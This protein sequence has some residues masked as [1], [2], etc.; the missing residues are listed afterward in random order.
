MG[1]EVVVAAEKKNESEKETVAKRAD[2]LRK[3]RLRIAKQG[4]S[5][6]TDSQSKEHSLAS[7]GIPGTK[8]DWLKLNLARSIMA[9]RYRK[10]YDKIRRNKTKKSKHQKYLER[11]RQRNESK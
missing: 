6:D 2:I 10:T 8:E 3:Q 5:M 7:D 4:R 9:K 1:R 11:K